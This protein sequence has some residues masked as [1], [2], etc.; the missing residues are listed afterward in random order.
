MDCITL[1]LYVLKRVRSPYI[2]E[3]EKNVATNTSRK[4]RQGDELVVF[5]ILLD[6]SPQSYPL[7]LPLT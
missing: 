4:C 2:G 7:L 6:G 3:E 1:S 5:E